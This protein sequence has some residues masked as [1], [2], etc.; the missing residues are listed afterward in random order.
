M[1]IQHRSLFIRHLLGTPDC[2]LLTTILLTHRN[3][4]NQNA[5]INSTISYLARGF[6][7]LQYVN[8]I[9]NISPY[10][11][12][13]SE[14]ILTRGQCVLN[15]AQQYRHLRIFSFPKMRIWSI[16]LIKSD[17]KW[18]IHLTRSIFHISIKEEK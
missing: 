13:N 12:Y 6:E 8:E 10:S 11:E 4:R 1:Y 2:K 7:G 18:C 5:N 14:D 15:R 16:L 17:L 9:N 3:T